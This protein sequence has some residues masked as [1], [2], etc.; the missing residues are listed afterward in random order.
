MRSQILIWSFPRTQIHSMGFHDSTW[1]NPLTPFKQSHTGPL[2]LFTNGFSRLPSWS[3]PSPITDLWLSMSITKLWARV[4]NNWHRTHACNN[5]NSVIK[6]KKKTKERNINKNIDATTGVPNTQSFSGVAS[7]QRSDM[8]FIMYNS[9]QSCQIVSVHSS[10]RWR[11]NPPRRFHHSLLFFSFHLFIHSPAHS[12]LRIPEHRSLVRTE[13]KKPYSTT[14]LRSDRNR[15]NI[16]AMQITWS[17]INHRRLVTC[18]S[19][20]T[21]MKVKSSNAARWF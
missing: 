11:S 8:I 9:F 15:T 12:T 13:W 7:W 2:Y 10:I 4:Q 20:K 18:A 14:L 3:V 1:T 5:L 17:L 6:S 21:M 19:L 16:L